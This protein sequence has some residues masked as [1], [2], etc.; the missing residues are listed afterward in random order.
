MSKIEF[1]KLNL[2]ENNDIITLH[3]GE[4]D[5]ALDIEIKQ[6]LPIDEKFII[7]SKILANSVDNYNFYNTVRI[8]SF[9]SLY[10]IDAYTNID[11]PKEIDANGAELFINPSETFDLLMGNDIKNDILSAI[12][13]SEIQFIYNGAMDMVK[14]I[15]T[16]NNSAAGILESVANKYKEDD[17]KLEEISKKISDPNTMGFLKDVITKLG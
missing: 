10:L 15:Y 12:P 3:Y 5:D 17:D 1:S 13:Q 9:L 14:S 11:L 16:Y 4:G 8:E 2:K 6:Y 7:I